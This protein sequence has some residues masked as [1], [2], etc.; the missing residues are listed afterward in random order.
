[1]QG[2]FLIAIIENINAQIKIMADAG[3]Q[4]YDNENFEYVI[5]D[6][7][8]SPAQDKLLVKFK[9]FEEVKINENN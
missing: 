8:Y 7:S 5:D 2:K 9:E 1:M 4:I 3:L 6:I